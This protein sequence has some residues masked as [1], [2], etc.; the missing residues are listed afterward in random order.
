MGQRLEYPARLGPPPDCRHP[1]H[2]GKGLSGLCP[3]VHGAS[4]VWASGTPPRL[5]CTAVLLSW[6]GDP[7]PTTTLDVL[8]PS[9]S[10]KP[11][12]SCLGFV[13]SSVQDVQTWK[14]P[15]GELFAVSGNWVTLEGAVPPGAA[16]SKAQGSKPQKY[17]K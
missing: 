2:P 13:L 4:G 3:G 16:V 6:G 10:P 14:S 7:P 5:P 12:S 11:L 1:C 15:P 8:R 17:R 9:L